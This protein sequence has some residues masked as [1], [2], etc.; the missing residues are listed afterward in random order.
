[1]TRISPFGARAPEE[2]NTLYLESDDCTLTLLHVEWTE[3]PLALTR[4]LPPDEQWKEKTE[5]APEERRK[6]FEEAQL[7]NAERIR[8]ALYF[9]GAMLAL[10]VVSLAFK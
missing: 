4:K 9:V 10:I 7:A 5:V 2:L 6:K 1:M 8:K 3:T